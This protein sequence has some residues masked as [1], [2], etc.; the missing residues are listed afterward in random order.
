MTAS[1]LKN[2]LLLISGV[3]ITAVSI[4]AA[5]AW[6]SLQHVNQKN[7]FTRRIITPELTILNSISKDERIVGISGSTAYHLYF[8]TKDP[9]KIWVTSNSLEHG[10]YIKLKI[11][12][13]SSVASAFYTVIDS[14]SVHVMAGNIPAIIETD[15]NGGDPFIRKFPT[16][17]FTR[18]VFIGDGSY[19]F[20]GFDTTEKTGGQIFIKGNPRKD[21]LLRAK[22]LIGN[23]TD[24]FG[25]STDGY[26]N[27][28]KHTGLLVYVSY[29][30][31]SYYCMD[32]T[33]SVVYTGRTIDTISSFQ[34]EAGRSGNL[35]TNTSP[36][37]VVNSKSRVSNGRL[38]NLSKLQADNED[39]GSFDKNA[40]MDIYDIMK[41]E[42]LGSIYI[43]YYKR[44]KP[45]DFKITSDKLFVLY[46]KHA[47]VY[48]LPSTMK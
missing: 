23:G 12:N 46:K 30:R 15:L 24:P 32:T 18:A 14:P 11:P 26:L 1:S 31:N 43:P 13:N 20:R 45:I 2:T 48:Q 19:V 9:S 22:N 42:Y 36:A 17:L 44:E 16:A 25:I 35:V 38:F 3:M 27:Y 7:G 34:V 40:V 33:L 47:V 10:K 37:R 21:E 41:R 5:L 28:D 39:R 29:Y 4:V 6:D 8:K